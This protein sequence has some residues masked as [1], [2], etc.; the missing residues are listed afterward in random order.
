VNGV[1]FFNTLRRGWRTALWWG[2]AI[3]ALAWLQIIIVQ[4]TTLIEQSAAIYETLPPFLL[5]MFGGSGDVAYLATPDGY[6]AL[7]FYGF[8]LV[9]F[10]IYALAAG[11]NITANDEENGILDVVMSL[12]LARSRLITERLAAYAVLTAF[13]LALSLSGILIGVAM[14]PNVSFNVERL[15]L[16]MLS[17]LPALLLVLAVTAAIATLVRR[18]SLAIAIGAA[19]VIGSYFLNVFAVAAPGTVLDRI[20]LL[21]FFHYAN[22]TEVIRTGLN[23]GSMAVLL[24]SAAAF[25][26][27]A[28]WAFQRRDIGL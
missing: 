11:L 16:G 20:A 15:A 18:R 3:G 2:L 21:S 14:V 10:A 13:V 27:L 24:V 1:L 4:D 12:P 25:S 5:Q 23:I 8:I 7:Q 6:I 26:G 9:V 28:L 22:S 17:F 19:F